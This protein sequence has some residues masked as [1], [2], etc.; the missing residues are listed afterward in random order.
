MS[1]STLLPCIEGI[2]IDSIAATYH[3][4][5]LRLAT[6]APYVACPLCGVQTGR[7]H[8]RYERTL[9]DLPWN[10]IA[11]R[12]HLRSRK[13]FC[14]NPAC[15]RSIFTEP[16]PELAARYARK[17]LRMQEVLYLIGYVLGG[18]AGA[19][20]AVGLGLSTSPDTL[21]RRVRQVAAQQSIGATGL[22]I[23]GV[24][25]WAFRKGHRY[26]TIL[27]DLEKRC[28]VDV[29][30][31]RTSESLAEWLQQHP[32]LAMISRDRAGVY[33]DGAR[34]GAPQAEQVAD[35]WHLLHNLSEAMQ[36][37]TAQHTPQLRQ[38]AEQMQPQTA[39]QP[40]CEVTKLARLPRVEQRRLERCA[41]REAL[42]RQI[43][44]LRQQGLTMNAIV[45]QVAVSKRTVQR[46]L[47]AEQFP[48]RARRRRQPCQTD[49]YEAYVRQRV[50]AGCH[51]ATQLYREVQAQGYAGAYPSIYHLVRRLKE[52]LALNIPEV[53]S[54]K[55]SSPD[56]SAVAV[57][58]SRSVA[59][60][61]QGHFTTSKPE[62]AEQQKIFLEHLYTRAP[63]LKEAA[64]LA[65]GFARMVKKRQGSELDDWLAKA[66]QSACREI[67][68]FA[69]GLRQ[70]LAAVKNAL[71][72]EWS[73]GQTEGQVNRLKMLKRQMYGRA[74]F[75][76]LRARVLPMALAA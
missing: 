31:D 30:P 72:L 29:L 16:L 2:A 19:R 54:R 53:C 34:Q 51:N 47:R 40:P 61:L 50:E 67:R 64:E 55:A 36:R 28:V 17:T 65:Q 44:T 23:V 24:D 27:I 6:N 15:G 43:K 71:T 46:F 11:V 35:R 7:V 62:I 42:Y 5:V 21:L 33:A 22:R 73:N 39:E 70:D 59:W 66:S 69:H 76:L 12:I 37:L 9:A 18:K 75:D 60:W 49:R 13:L 48:A 41:E 63:V 56:N 14:D 1:V 74:N 68:L 20:V 8:S 4:I 26:G 10:R 52:T 58:P 3:S 45:G 32:T 25:D 38:T 57:P